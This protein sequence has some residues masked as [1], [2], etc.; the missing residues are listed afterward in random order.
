MYCSVPFLSMKITVSHTTFPGAFSSGGL[1]Y[2]PGSKI[3]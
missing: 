3:E 2:A 1:E